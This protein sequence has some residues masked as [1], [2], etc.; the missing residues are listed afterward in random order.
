MAGSRGRCLLR[1]RSPYNG[2]VLAAGL[3][4]VFYGVAADLVMLVHGAFVLFVVFGVALVWQWPWL[5]WLHLPALVWGVTVVL[6]GWICPLTPLEN[7]LRDLA[8]QQAYQ[9]GFI[10]HYL[11]PLL[12]PQ[13]PGPLLRIMVVTL[14]ALCH[15]YVYWRLW[16]RWRAN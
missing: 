9:G 2:R 5:A 10:N 11:T 8:G 15:V 12:Y 7:H 3:A 6:M 1:G 4:T 14:L 16:R 13:T